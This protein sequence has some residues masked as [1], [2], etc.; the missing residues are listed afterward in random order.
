VLARSGNTAR[1]E[2]ADL[3]HTS[4]EW[5]IVARAADGGAAQTAHLTAVDP[6]RPSPSPTRGVTRGQAARLFTAENAA[7]ANTP[8]RRGIAAKGSA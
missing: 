6:C 5:W 7:N 4:V 8:V 2:R 1:G 3:R